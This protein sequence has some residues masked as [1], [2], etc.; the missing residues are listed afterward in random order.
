MSTYSVPGPILDLPVQMAE[1]LLH[2]A[3]VLVGYIVSEQ[4][5][6]CVVC[7]GQG[8][9]GA[10]RMDLKVSRVLTSVR[11]NS[12]MQDHCEELII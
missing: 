5:N 9:E 10:W 12:F 6:E 7:S 2:G 4:V 1:S 11:L 8:S 3:H